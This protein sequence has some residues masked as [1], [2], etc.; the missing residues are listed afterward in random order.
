MAGQ[1]PT[2]TEEV[3]DGMQ[4]RDIYLSN[5]DLNSL[6]HIPLFVCEKRTCIEQVNVRYE[7][8]EAGGA[9]TLKLSYQVNGTALGSSPV[10]ITGTINPTA[11]AATNYTLSLATASTGAVPTNNLVPAG[12]VVLLHANAGINSL[13]RVTIRVRTQTKIH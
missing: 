3:C 10:D 8:A 9:T 13:D 11:T 6:Q 4:Y 12:A 2:V 7:T 1:R 5:A